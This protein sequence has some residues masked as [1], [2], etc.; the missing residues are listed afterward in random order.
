MSVQSA[1]L[2]HFGDAAA[3]VPAAPLPRR[4]LAD[5]ASAASAEQRR[6]DLAEQELAELDPV[7]SAAL[8]V[9][10][11][12]RMRDEAALISTLHLLTTAVAAWEVRQPEPA[13]DA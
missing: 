8:L 3:P 4:P 1:L 6:A 7:V 13:N 10:S 9:A 2:A 5:A 11:A 12:F